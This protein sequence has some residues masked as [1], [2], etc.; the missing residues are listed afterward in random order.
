[1]SVEIEIVWGAGDGQTALG[2][3]DAALSAAGIENYNHV[4]LSSV[5]PADAR[6]IEQGTHDQRWDVGSIVASVLSSRRSTVSGETIAAGLG[7]AIAE[8]GGIFFEET[9]ASTDTVD[10]LIKRGIESGKIHRSDWNWQDDVATRICEHTVDDNGAVV[11]AALF[12]PL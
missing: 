10:S 7:W 3:F 9:G 12:R 8:E 2:A 1:M 5:I 6:I 4:R 11:V